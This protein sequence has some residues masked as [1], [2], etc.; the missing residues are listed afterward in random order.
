MSAV[1]SRPEL[2][3]TPHV[4]VPVTE[5]IHERRRLS[6]WTPG[7]WITIA[8][9]T[10][11]IVLAALSAGGDADS[12][13][14]VFRVLVVTAAACMLPGLPV[15]LLLRMPGIALTMTVAAPLSLAVTVMVAQVQIVAAWWHPIAAQTAVAAVAIVLAVVGIVRTRGHTPRLRFGWLTAVSPV[16][17]GLLVVALGLFALAVRTVEPA[18]AGPT[19][20]VTHV[21]PFYLGALA[22]VAVVIVRA[23]TMRTIVAWFMSASVVTLVVVTA[24]LTALAS[25]NPSFPTAFVHRSIIQVLTENGRLPAPVD[26][27]FSWAGFFSGAG[28]LVE[29]AGLRDAGPFLLWAPVATEILMIAPLLVI[30]RCVSA[31][32][33]TIWTGVV[34]YQL[35]NW[36]QQDYFA[37][38]AVAAL[39]YTS[40]IALV[41]WQ[42]RASRLP[43]LRVG[44][45]SPRRTRVTV[46]LRAVVHRTPGRVWGRGPGW[47]LA[48]DLVCLVVIAGMVV[49]HQLTPV[50][51]VAAF[52]I[53]TVLGSIRSRW[54]WLAA[55]TMFLAWFSYGATDYWVGHIDDL[56]GDVG[57]V[58]NAVG[59]GVAA[60]L[61]AD[62]RYQDMQYLRLLTSGALLAVA[63]VGWF[64]IRRRRGSI[65]IGMLALC[66]F[67]LVAVQSY[68]GEVVIRCFVLASPILAPL[69][70]VAVGHAYRRLTRVGV[71]RARHAAWSGQGWRYRNRFRIAACASVMGIAALSVVLTID[72]GVNTEFETSSPTQVRIGR[73]VVADAPPDSTILA[74]GPTPG[75]ADARMFLD[76]RLGSIDSLAC[77]DDLAACTARQAPDYVVVSRQSAAALRLQQG[78][79]T[80]VLREQLSQLAAAGYEPMIDANGI[81]VYRRDDAPSIEVTP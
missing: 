29:T 52:G 22:V 4:A 59:G 6:A 41:L 5:Q 42:F 78:Y 1:L 47:T 57:Q 20:I 3:G 55:A 63:A 24:M 75:L 72:R 35:F 10:A 60:R 17:P 56:F 19:G 34:L 25:G 46:R 67:G 12:V 38:Q 21:G 9:G 79:P 8:L 13:P 49:T 43:R 11:T 73:A 45:H 58:Q 76:V 14:Q 51:T 7:F 48:V 26:A 23:L 54:M 30:G 81:L 61:G 33:R 77:L 69:A 68:G 28:Q 53:A 37:P 80:S 64:C 32:P 2:S 27:R 39:Q 40:L 66:P 18:D 44:R 71:V 74:W 16:W 70:A 36:Y 31:R 65:L 50:V 15:A 62:P